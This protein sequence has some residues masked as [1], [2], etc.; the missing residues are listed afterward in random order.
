[1]IWPS[2]TRSSE[3]MSSSCSVASGVTWSRSMSASLTSSSTTNSLISSAVPADTVVAPLL[4]VCV[5]HRRERHPQQVGLAQREVPRRPG[6]ELLV[7]RDDVL[8]H[9]LDGALAVG[10]QPPR[11][12]DERSRVVEPVV[13]QGDHLEAPL[14]GGRQLGQPRRVDVREDLGDDEPEVAPALAVEVGVALGD[15]LERQPAARHEPVAAALEE[16]REDLHPRL[17]VGAEADEV[18]DR[19]DR[20]DRVVRGL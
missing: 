17:A 9:Q 1:M 19:A 13:A 6:E 5:L 14:A 8:A 16:A 2:S 18:L 15:A 11:P 12:L 4:V 3:S 10:A 7:A 20:D